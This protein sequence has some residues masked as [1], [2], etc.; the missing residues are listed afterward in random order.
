MLWLLY[1]SEKWIYPRYIYICVKSD[2]FNPTDNPKQPVGYFTYE[3][4]EH[5]APIFLYLYSRTTYR[6]NRV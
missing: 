4:I 6:L 3:Q 5:F 2:N 1:E